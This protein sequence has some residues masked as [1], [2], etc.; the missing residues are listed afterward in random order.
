MLPNKMIGKDNYCCWLGPLPLLCFPCFCNKYYCGLILVKSIVA[1][2]KR[3]LFIC[4]FLFLFVCMCDTATGN[5]DHSS[6]KAPLLFQ[7]LTIPSLLH[8]TYHSLLDWSQKRNPFERISLKYLQYFFHFFGLGYYWGS[9]IKW[10]RSWVWSCIQI[11]SQPCI[12]SVSMSFF[13]ASV[14]WAIRVSI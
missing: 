5:T 12:N 6:G 8:Y 2:F 7:S 14:S 9:I 3:Y 1:W 11:I 10:F 4:L 13:C